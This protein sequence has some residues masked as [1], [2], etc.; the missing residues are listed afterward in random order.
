[1]IH[2]KVGGSDVEISAITFGAWAIG[3]WLWGGTD[4]DEAIGAIHKAIE[5]GITSIDTAAIYGFGHSE[6]VVGR[7]LAGVKRDEVQVL[8]KFGLRWD[9]DAG[10]RCFE[11][12]GAE[13]KARAVRRCATKESVDYECEQ[14]LRRL[15]TDYIDLYQCHWRDHTTPVDET[16][17]ALA[18]LIDDGKIRAAGVSN[19]GV[20]EIDA[21]RRAGPLASN[22]PP[23]SMLRR[24]IEKEMVPYCIEHGVGLIA[25]STLERGL[26]TG[27]VTMDRTFGKGDHRAGHPFFQPENRRRILAFL[28]RIRPVADAHD[29]TLAQLAVNWTIHRP[30][31][32]AALVGARNARQVEE[33]AGAAELQLTG[34]E[35]ARIEEELGR[36]KL[37]AK[38]GS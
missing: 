22:Q 36:L 23:Y 12:T 19:F 8:T 29:A 38:A 24:D 5:L 34:E 6:V 4:D 13:G 27:K 10:E 17:E 25:Y 1:M 15:R 32:T 16:M 20:E 7:A 26:L 18:K 30:G 9:T 33:N 11:T 14:S 31:I 28:D 35:L 3:G 37:E 2:R 21:A